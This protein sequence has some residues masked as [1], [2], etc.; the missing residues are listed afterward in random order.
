MLCSYH[1]HV[2]RIGQLR[3]G[4][5]RMRYVGYDMKSNYNTNFQQQR[6]NIV[7]VRFSGSRLCRMYDFRN[8]VSLIPRH[9]A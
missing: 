4:F 9:F 7:H 8:N 6:L 1:R 5:S 3:T 2:E